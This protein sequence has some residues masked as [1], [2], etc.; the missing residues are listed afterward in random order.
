MSKKK[1]MILLA[2]IAVGVGVAALVASHVICLSHEWLP[3]TCVK[4]E[5]CKYCGAFQGD[6]LGH[7]WIDATCMEPK[8]CKICEE[9]EG[10]VLEHQWK[11]ANCTTPKRC[12]VCEET[13]GTALG[14]TPGEYKMGAQSIVNGY[15]N[16]NQ[17][18]EDCGMLLDQK[19]C[20]YISFVDGDH[21]LLTPNQFMERCNDFAETLNGYTYNC[22]VKT[23]DGKLVG[24]MQD[25]YGELAV[26][27]TFMDFG[28]D[29]IIEDENSKNV[30]AILAAAYDD[31]AVV[32]AMCGMVYACDPAITR[33]EVES[34][35]EN[36]LEAA[37][38]DTGYEH[39]GV[40]YM[41]TKA[42]G[43]LLIVAAIGK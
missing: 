30:G 23:I 20:E 17:M 25:K 14:H 3:A 31:N 27:F 34:V 13:E 24:G 4:S 35:C 16:M 6:P 42:G 38:N 19:K 8:K 33:S 26:A 7:D 9:L 39:N 28:M 22:T 1:K 41:F 43:M 21:F 36:I 29:E 32:Y 37:R 2:L 40:K 10:N 11:D 5:V 18:C 12:S 15:Y